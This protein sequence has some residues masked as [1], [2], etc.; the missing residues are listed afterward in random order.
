[1]SGLSLDDLKPDI[2]SISLDELKLISKSRGIEG[3][4]NMSGKRLLS[5]LNKPEI[6]S[7]R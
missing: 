5:L 1:M 7:E 4:K 2:E 3:Y 6:D